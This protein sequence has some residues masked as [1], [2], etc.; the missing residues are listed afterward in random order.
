MSART[1]HPRGR[2]IA[3]WAPKPPNLEEAARKA[4]WKA[5]SSTSRSPT[6]PHPPGCARP[7]HRNS[8]RR[9][10]FRRRRRNHDPQ[11]PAPASISRKVLEEARGVARPRSPRDR[12]AQDFRGLPIV[13]IDGETARDFDDAVL[14]RKRADGDYEL[15]V[16]IADVA[17][18]V[19]PARPSILKRD[20]AARR[21]TFPTAPCPCFRRNSRLISAAC[22]LMRNASCS[23]ASWKSTTRAR[24]WA[25][26]SRGRHPL[27]RAHDLH[28]RS[29]PFSTESRPARG[30]PHLCESFELH[31][32]SRAY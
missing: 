10:R 5:S 23:P 30:V 1:P 20:C 8:R 31:V 14:V 18:Y 32:S 19:P 12:P 17:H 3:Y 13:T 22:A 28:A 9:R 25:T 29:R 16:H 2:P 6:G 15:Q 27:R 24:S 7:R 4:N 21:S 26:R 11:A